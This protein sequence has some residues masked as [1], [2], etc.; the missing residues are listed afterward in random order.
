MSLLVCGTVFEIEHVP[1]ARY[2][3]AGLLCYR[4][5]TTLCVFD[6]RCLHTQ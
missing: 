1:D 6:R 2:N 3:V 4:V 5:T